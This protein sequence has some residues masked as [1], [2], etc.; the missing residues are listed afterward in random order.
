MFKSKRLYESPQ[1]VTY[2]HLVALTKGTSGTCP[3]GQV[4]AKLYGAGDDLSNQLQT[5]S[6]FC[7][8]P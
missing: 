5:S 7:Y 6:T 4:M 8:A 1:L 3:A 2:G